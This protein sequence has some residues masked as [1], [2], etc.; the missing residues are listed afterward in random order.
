MTMRTSYSKGTGQILIFRRQ[1]YG[2]GKTFHSYDISQLFTECL[3]H[4]ST[5]FRC[6]TIK[7]SKKQQQKKPKKKPVLYITQVGMCLAQW[8]TWVS[9]CSAQ[10]HFSIPSF[11][12]VPDTQQMLKYK[13][14]KLNLVYNDSPDW[15]GD[16]SLIL[17]L[18]Y[19][20]NDHINRNFH[21]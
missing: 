3:L 15:T 4:T 6:Q 21:L 17:Y 20:V 13:F 19:D 11:S 2:N 18:K 9:A 12:T 1:V 14:I 8:F 10:N 7:D 5:Q 16:A